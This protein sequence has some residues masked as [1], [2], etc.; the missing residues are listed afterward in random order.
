MEKF[1]KRPN[2]IYNFPDRPTFILIPHHEPFGGQSLG[3]T[4][5][6]ELVSRSKRLTQ[7]KWVRRFQ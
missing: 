1:S 2:L 4:D 5:P 7:D 6:F 3:T